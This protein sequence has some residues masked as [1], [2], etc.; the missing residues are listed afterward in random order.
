M[1][2]KYDEDG[3]I[4]IKSPYMFLGCVDQRA[5]NERYLTVDRY[6]NDSERTRQALDSEGFFKT[7]DAVDIHGG[8]LHL[9]GRIGFDCRLY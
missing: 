6:V 7:G 5:P 1:S 3:Q 4:C 8:K 2:I 9:L